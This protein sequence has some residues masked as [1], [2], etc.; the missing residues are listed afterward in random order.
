HAEIFYNDCRVK[1]EATEE[2]GHIVVFT[3]KAPF[4]CIEN[5]SC[6]TDCFNLFAKGFV[7]ESGLQTVKAG[8]KKSGAIRFVFEK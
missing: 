8:E 7:R 2:F 6:S 4:F 1:L 3:P 5:Q